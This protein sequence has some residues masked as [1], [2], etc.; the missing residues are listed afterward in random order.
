VEP[1]PA[2]DIRIHRVLPCLV[3]VDALL[4]RSGEDLHRYGRSFTHKLPEVL[5]V[6][7]G[8]VRIVHNHA[9][10]FVDGSGSNVGGARWPGIMTVVIIARRS[11]LHTRS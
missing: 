3:T 6:L 9:L 7:G 4:K 1:H 10:P 8:Q 5:L 11:S 2:D